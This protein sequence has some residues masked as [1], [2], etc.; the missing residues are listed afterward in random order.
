M[1]V[2]EKP[3]AAKKIAIALDDSRSPQEIKKWK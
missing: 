2:T 3:T 1:L